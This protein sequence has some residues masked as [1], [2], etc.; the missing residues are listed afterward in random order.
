MTAET[1]AVLPSLMVVLAAAIWAVAVV[2]AQLECVDAARAG[3]RAAARGESI[4]QVRQ[5]VA[6]LAPD[7]AEVAVLR[8]ARTTRVSVSAQVRPKWGERL[9]AV[10]VGSDAA[11]IT[12]PGADEATT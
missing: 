7:G 8:D 9:P 5:L 3:A 6:D 2:G 1:A 4:E 12:E 10:S 11:A